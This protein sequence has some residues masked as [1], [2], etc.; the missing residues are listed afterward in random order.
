MAFVWSFI[1][2]KHFDKG[3]KQQREKAAHKKKEKR[4]ERKRSA[5]NDPDTPGAD[6][7]IEMKHR[8]AIDD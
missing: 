3:L 2:L 8:M 1:V 5:S 6:M 4:A 7:E